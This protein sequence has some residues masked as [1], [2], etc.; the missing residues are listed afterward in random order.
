MQIP[1][2]VI[3]IVALVALANAWLILPIIVI[4][5]IIFKLRNFFLKTA[6]NIKRLEA[7][8]NYLRAKFLYFYT[9][10]L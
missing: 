6:Q 2:T 10:K 7:T 4:I 5:V 9:S 1:L 8:S 3:G